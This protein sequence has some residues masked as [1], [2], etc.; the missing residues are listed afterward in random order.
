MLTNIKKMINLYKTAKVFLSVFI[1]AFVIVLPFFYESVWAQSNDDNDDYLN[2]GGALRFNFFLEDYDGDFNPN[3]FQATFDTW[4]INVNARHSGVGINFEYRFYPTFNTHF[5]K[6]GWFEYDFTPSTQIQ[7]GVTQ[8]PFGNLQYNSHNWWFQGGYYV[9]LED[10]HDMGIKLIR[11]SDNW[12][13]QLAYFFQPEPAGPAY[14]TASF[15]TGGPGRYSY[16][17]IPITGNNPWDYVLGPDEIP[18]SNQEKN[19]FNLR[20]VYDFQH[21]G[22]NNSL[23]GGSV[24]YGGIYNSAQ[25]QYNGRIALA[26]HLDGNY[27]NFNVKAQIAYYDNDAIN[28]EGQSVDYVY[29]AAYG[30]PYPVAASA[31][32][33][34]LGIA[35]SWDV[36]FGPVS[37]INFYNNYTLF[38]KSNDDFFNSHQ[39]VLG[40]LVTMGN[41][42]AYFD[43]ASGVNHPWLTSNFGTGLGQGQDDARLNTRFNINIGYYF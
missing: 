2:V 26:G 23:I 34:S 42:F 4:R 25:D 30:D 37:N 11:D 40:A 17:I 38:D 22:G 32:L 19:Q 29:M 15:G 3:D 39:N 16:D 7:L 41:I 21:E 10:D 36:E 8:V 27:G 14:G 6:Q 20:Y 24:Q 1:A 5:I 13:L 28:D 12:N 43:I 33:Y 9:G 18:Q 31:T 35:Y